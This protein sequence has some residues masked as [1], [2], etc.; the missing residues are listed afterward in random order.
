MGPYSCP[1][2]AAAV[3]VVGLEK[4]FVPSLPSLLLSLLPP[5]PKRR[6]RDQ[7]I[8]VSQGKLFIT[9]SQNVA[10]SRP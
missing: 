2:D 6:E 9:R 5:Q 3:V 8:Q 10:A 7:Y 1:A 4:P